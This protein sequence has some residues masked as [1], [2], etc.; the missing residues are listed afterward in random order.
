MEFEYNAK[1]KSKCWYKNVCNHQYCD[2]N[3]MCL[4]NYKMNFLVQHAMIE[5]KQREYVA[6]YPD[7][8]DLNA[9]QRLKTIQNNINDF[10]NKGNNLLIYSKYTGNGK[11]SWANKIMMSWFDSIWSKTDFECRGLFILLPRLMQSMKE[12]MQKPNEYYQYVNDIICS[13][14]LVVWDEINY[15]ELTQFEQDYLLNVISQRISLGKSNI[16]TTNYSLKDIQ[17][18]LGSRLASRIIGCSE[19]IELVGKDK[20]GVAK[21]V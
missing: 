14:D 15:K 2:E 11:T 6:L 17:D 21:N 13:V 16:Y 18:R 4:R 3:T 10:V 20:R 1:N 19:C 8:E 5:G 12:N 9:F 7:S